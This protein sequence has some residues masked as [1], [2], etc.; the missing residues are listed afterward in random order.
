MGVLSEI[1]ATDQGNQQEEPRLKTN[2]W[3]VVPKVA[4][5]PSARPKCSCDHIAH[6]SGKSLP[7]KIPIQRFRLAPN[8]FMNQTPN[9]DTKQFI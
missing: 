8:S 7:K 4:V 6:A 5:T 2:V 1:R 9:R 3:S